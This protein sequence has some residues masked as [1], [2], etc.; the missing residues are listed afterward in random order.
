ME[1]TTKIDS[2][3]GYTA[4]K[5][6]PA[7]LGSVDA[8]VGS[9]IDIHITAAPDDPSKD[10]IRAAFSE[11]I[12]VTRHVFHTAQEGHGADLASAFLIAADIILL[13]ITLEEDVQGLADHHILHPGHISGIGILCGGLRRSGIRSRIR[14]RYDNRRRWRDPGVSVRASFSRA[15]LHMTATS[16]AS[17]FIHG[18][19]YQPATEAEERRKKERQ[20]HDQKHLQRFSRSRAFRAGDHGIA[21][22]NRANRRSAMIQGLIERSHIR[23]TVPGGNGHTFL[24]CGPL[25]LR[26]AGDA[27]PGRLDLL[28]DPVRG[29]DRH[30]SGQA[31][32]NSRAEGIFIG[33]G[34]KASPGIVLLDRCEA[35]L[36]DGFRGLGQRRIHTG[37]LDGADSAK[38]QELRSRLIIEHDIIRADVPMDQSGLMDDR[39]GM[40][41]RLQQMK[42]LFQG[43]GPSLEHEMLHISSHEILHDDIGRIVR[44]EIITDI[45]DGADIPES[46][47]GIRLPEESG[48]AHLEAML[49]LL[50]DALKIQ[51]QRVI[52]GHDGLRIE[53]LHRHRL[54]QK[55]IPGL[56]GDAKA[57]LTQDLP[58][59]VPLLQYGTHGK[60]VPVLRHRVV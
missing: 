42:G 25:A 19:I 34:A 21:L 18:I 37:I 13:R 53:F 8:S 17:A 40:E 10:L 12:G 56:I 51:A 54:S 58:D 2:R 23:E 39:Q 30:F 43:Q 15:A 46:L 7:G 22:L 9:D 3:Q 52:S 48:L 32:V 49:F 27:V 33:P 36:Q 44:L 24:Q 55:V 14:I 59:L 57:A 6:V 38:I 16:A 41:Y 47:Q 28:R 26:Q 45:H 35:V 60:P 11:P 50:C 29:L 20:K 5:E 1:G 4:G 31:V